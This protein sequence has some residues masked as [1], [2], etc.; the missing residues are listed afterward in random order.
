MSTLFKVGLLTT[1]L[2]F[3]AS[4]AMATSSIDLKVTGKIIPPSC[5][6]AFGAG[7]GTVDFGNILVSTLSLTNDTALK[8]VKQVPVTITCDAPT[9]VGITFTDQR[10]NSRS[11]TPMS[12][13]FITIDFPNLVDYFFGLGLTA[14][15]KQ[16]GVYAVGINTNGAK[17]STGETRFPI[18]SDDNGK[19]WTQALSDPDGQWYDPLKNNGT[20]ITAFAKDGESQ[21][22]PESSLTFNVAVAAIIQDLQTLHVTDQITL[23]G[24]TSINLVYL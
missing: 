16:I 6:P 22:S 24:L 15:Q 17:T 11:T 4:S 13:G 3:V 20:Q 23:D 5:T 18:Y 21:V 12:K 14:E 9:R 10:A 1:A 19:T 8:D 2:A 7:G